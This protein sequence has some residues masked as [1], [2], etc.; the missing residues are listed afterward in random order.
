MSTRTVAK[1]FD[2][3]GEH[4]EKGARLDA[5]HEL[6]RIAPHLFVPRKTKPPAEAKPKRIRITEPATVVSTVSIPPPPDEA[7]DEPTKE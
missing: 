6:V 2:H 7:S 1:A 4:Y 5:D 3:N